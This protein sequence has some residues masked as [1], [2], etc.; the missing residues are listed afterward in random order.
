MEKIGIEGIFL[1]MK[2][3]FIIVSMTDAQVGVQVDSTLHHGNI[4][5]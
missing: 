4:V 3:V 5:N 1:I 2:M